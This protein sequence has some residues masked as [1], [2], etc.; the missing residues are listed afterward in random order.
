MLAMFMTEGTRHACHIGFVWDQVCL[1][2]F[3]IGTRYACHN[4]K[5]KNPFPAKH[6]HF[7]SNLI[8][9]NDAQSKCK[10]YGPIR[11]NRKRTC[12]I[13][14]RFSFFKLWQAYLVPIRKDGRH[15]W[16]E[17]KLIWQACLVPFFMS[18][19]SIHGPYHK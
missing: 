7:R 13:E 9:G 5:I 15:T 10:S 17:P 14:N 3:L 16:S 19:A 18:M 4:L 8:G 2:S 6:V 1:P 12:F 11:L